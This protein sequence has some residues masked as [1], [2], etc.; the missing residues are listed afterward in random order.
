MLYPLMLKENAMMLQTR[1]CTF[2]V[3]EMH[4]S[5]VLI[6]KR[7]LA[8]TTPELLLN[9]MRAMA[10]KAHHFQK[11]HYHPAMTTYRVTAQRAVA[12]RL[13]SVRS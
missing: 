6:E 2:S 7:S 4:D 10:R 11:Q 9:S 12:S 8:A 3:C 5:V 1:N 13:Q